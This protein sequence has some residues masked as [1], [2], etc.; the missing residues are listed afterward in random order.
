[1]GILL[2]G[3]YSWEGAQAQYLAYQH[4]A[5]RLY[6]MGVMTL[7][8]SLVAIFRGSFTSN[9]S[10]APQEEKDAVTEH[11]VDLHRQW[12]KDS[13]LLATCDDIFSRAGPPAGTK[14]WS[15]YEVWAVPDFETVK[16]MLDSY[17][18]EDGSLRLDKFFS[19]EVV[20]GPRIGPVER[21]ARGK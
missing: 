7:T 20:V 8:D 17:R 3:E 12:A 15:F 2:T 9:W 5:Q 16:A 19:I 11:W 4:S 1:M 6:R 10:S 18:P 13:E 14:M 21:A